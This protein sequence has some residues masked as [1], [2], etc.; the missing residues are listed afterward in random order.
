MKGKKFLINRWK[1]KLFSLLIPAFC[2][3]LLLPGRAEIFASDMKAGASAQAPPKWKILH[4]MSY[5]SPWQWTD[6]MFNGFKKALNGLDIEYKVFQMDTKRKSSEEWKQKAGKEARDLIDTWKPDLVYT[7]DDNAQE[8]VTKYYI[9]SNIPF[10]FAG[11]NADPE[12]YGFVGTK[13]I[14]GVL[15]QEHFVQTVMLLKEVAPGISRIAV[16]AD[17]DPT[18]EGVTR[19]MKENASTYL[20]DVQFIS[21]DVIHTFDEYKQKIKAYQTK[22]DALGLLGIHTF[23]NE[24]GSNVPWQE[25]LKWTAYHSRLPDFSFW[26]DRIPYGTLC[27]VIVSASEQGLAAGRIARG[28]LAEGKSPSSYAIKPTIK[29]QPMLS[30]ARARKLG[31]RVK[32]KVLLTAQVIEKFEW[33]K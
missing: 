8:Y 18:W 14:T 9:D 7:T 4:I 13:N 21:Y 27:A 11:V 17:T 32:S 15:E 24:K 31:I 26:A 25:V 1:N 2:L 19:R 6:D 12:K 23:K 20:P 28:I 29:G 16:I 5:H 3:S 30:L 33:D 22:A 10:V